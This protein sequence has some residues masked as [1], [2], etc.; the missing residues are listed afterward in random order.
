M[1]V[2]MTVDLTNE[3]NT[4]MS[5]IESVVTYG[6]R[7]RTANTKSGA[8]VLIFFDICKK[9][10]TFLQIVA[11]REACSFFVHFT[12]QREIIVPSG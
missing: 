3:V 4:E 9:N 6:H 5:V 8:M 11:E 12:I 1:E 2:V 10:I 7:S